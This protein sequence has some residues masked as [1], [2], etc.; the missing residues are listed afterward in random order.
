MDLER[1]L[2][3]DMTVYQKSGEFTA[4]SA[5]V[6]NSP[7]VVRC[8]WATTSEKFVTNN[9]DEIY[10]KAWISCIEEFDE[11]DLV[12]LGNTAYEPDPAAAGA[13]ELKR[14]SS[15]PDLSADNTMHIY[16]V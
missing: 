8:R 10:V 12:A 11:G 1:K 2:N 14:H 15:I 13:E 4:S 16:F 7:V 9:G 6:V 5:P 3:Q